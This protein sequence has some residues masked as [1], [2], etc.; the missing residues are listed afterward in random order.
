[1][2][3]LVS[4]K[5]Y[6]GRRI[7]ARVGGKN[8]R[9]SEGL[10][11]GICHQRTSGSKQEANAPIIFIRSVGTVQHVGNGIATLRRF[12]DGF[13]EELVTFPNGVQGMGAELDRKHVDV[14]LLGDD[15]GIRAG[16]WLK[17]QV[18]G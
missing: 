9:A 7:K 10:Q 6:Y 15:T 4:L 12:A 3:L 13:L 11:C 5:E 14:I 2:T 16:T 18:N 1:M 17:Q 8:A